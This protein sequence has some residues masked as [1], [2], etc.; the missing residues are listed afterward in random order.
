MSNLAD[1]FLQSIKDSYRA[2]LEY[3]ARSTEKLK[4]AHQWL[5]DFLR[6]ELG[7]EYRIYGMRA[8]DDSAREISVEGL[9]YGKDVDIAVKYKGKTVSCMGFKFVTSNYKQNSVN[10]FEGLLGETA[11]IQRGDVGYGALT[12]LPSVIKYLRKDGGAQ[13]DETVSTHNLEKYLHLY[14]DKDFPHKPEALGLVFVDVDYDDGRVAGL[15]DVASMDFSPDICAFLK[16]SANLETFLDVFVKLTKY[17]AAKA[18][19]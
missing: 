13:K 1:G 14:R 9:Y 10:Y 16:N 6:A 11:N 3:G 4:P 7:E 5:A 18:C 2:Y 8:D 17:K 19:R 12:V 15:T